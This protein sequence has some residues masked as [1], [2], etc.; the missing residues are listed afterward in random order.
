MQPDVRHSIKDAFEFA[1]KNGFNHVELLMDHPYYSLE[2]LSPIEVLELKWSYDLEVLLHAPATS[3]NFISISNCMRKA[4][5][6]ELRRVCDFAEK[7]DAKVVTFHI[8]WNPGFINS[9]DFYFDLS[10]YD[11]HNEKVLRD[12]MYRFLRDVDCPLAL[13]NT[14]VIEGGLERALNFLLENTDLALTFDVGHHNIAR[15]DFFIKNFNRVINVHLH[16]NNGKR[17]EHLALGKGN[18]NLNEIPLKSYNGYLTIETRE[19]KSIIETKNYIIRWLNE[20]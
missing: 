17:D 20:G 9:G 19:K 12:E 6:E 7:C 2:N 5:Y 18:V 13:E 3:T 15:N 10:L 4:S 11:E 16:D 1:S 8:G 14:I